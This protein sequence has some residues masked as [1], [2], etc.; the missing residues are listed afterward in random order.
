[1]IIGPV[2]N[3]IYWIWCSI[4]EYHFFG[5]VLIGIEIYTFKFL[6]IVV[7]KKMLPI[8]DDFM[9]M[10]LV[11]TN[12]VVGYFLGIV[13]LYSQF[14]HFSETRFVGWPSELADLSPID[15]K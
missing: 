4:Q 15:Y 7:Y 13:S 3:Y 9:A 11:A 8:L 1:M 6:T 5:I 10:F 14:N 2:N 12:M